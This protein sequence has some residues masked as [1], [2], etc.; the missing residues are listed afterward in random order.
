MMNDG[1]LELLKHAQGVWPSDRASVGLDIACEWAVKKLDCLQS[2][3]DDYARDE[4]IALK[5]VEEYSHE[6]GKLQSERDELR[7]G[8]AAMK[9]ER[10][11]PRWAERTLLKLKADEDR[12][13]ELEAIVDELPKCWRLVDGELRED[14][15]VVPGMVM[16]FL[17]GPSFRIELYERTVRTI[18]ADGWLT[19]VEEGPEQS[20][21]RNSEDCC[22]SRAA[23]EFVKQAEKGTG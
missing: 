16:Y 23:A 15:P 11:C 18:E 19:W 22:N 20:G 4:A 10:D 14:C 17:F 2:E 13:N 12:R 21:G 3:R 6:I 8:V 5:Q 1:N 7:L 9:A